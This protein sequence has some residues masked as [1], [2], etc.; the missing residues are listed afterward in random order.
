[1]TRQVSRTLVRSPQRWLST[2]G[3]LG[4][5]AQTASRLSLAALVA[6]TLGGCTTIEGSSGSC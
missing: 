6:I 1:M 5:P 4:A 3:W 2:P